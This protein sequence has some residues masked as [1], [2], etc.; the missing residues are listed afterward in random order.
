M[1]FKAVE[2]QLTKY[3]CLSSLRAHLLDC[4]KPRSEVTRPAIPAL[5]RRP[6]RTVGQL[7]DTVQLSYELNLVKVI[8]KKELSYVS[9]FPHLPKQ[10]LFHTLVYFILVKYDLYLPKIGL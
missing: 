3:F 4:H 2:M 9:L 8:L 6:R 1:L 7:L 5:C 10:F